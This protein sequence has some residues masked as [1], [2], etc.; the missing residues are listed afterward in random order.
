M[1]FPSFSRWASCM[2]RNTV[3]KCGKNA[4]KKRRPMDAEEE[5]RKSRPPFVSLL[6]YC[7]GGEGKG[8]TSQQQDN[9]TLLCW[10]AH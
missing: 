9:H 7:G 3:L 8:H 5:T 4:I 10:L 2:Y 6:V 1:I